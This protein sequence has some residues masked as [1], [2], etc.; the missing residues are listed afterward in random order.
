MSGHGK[1]AYRHASPRHDRIRPIVPS[2]SS[3][4]LTGLSLALIAA[5]GC[6]VAPLEMA[7]DTDEL[8][9]LEALAWGDLRELE[10]LLAGDC[11]A[12]SFAVRLA[13]SSRAKGYELIGEPGLLSV[14]MSSAS[15]L[16]TIL[17]LYPVT[18]LGGDTPP[19]ALMRDDDSGEAGL[20]A[21]IDV[22][23]DAKPED[24][25]RSPLA[26]LVVSQWAPQTDAELRLTVSIDGVALCPAEGSQ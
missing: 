18:D 13:Q 11:E 10:V 2:L 20:S 1:V 24:S 19:Q 7:K 5:S 6:D 9:A 21:L 4:L 25:P 16:D 26:H 14:T 22:V 12:S 23:L 8:P 17:T 15:A 3:R